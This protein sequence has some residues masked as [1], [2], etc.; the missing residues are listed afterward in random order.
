[1]IFKLDEQVKRFEMVKRGVRGLLCGGCVVGVMV[2]GGCG[3]EQHGDVAVSELGVKTFNTWVVPADDGIVPAPRSITIG[4]DDRV[5]V[6]DNGGR[7][8]IYSKDGELE[9]QFDM[10]TNEAGNPEGACWLRDGRIVVADTHYFRLVFFNEDGE[11]VETRGSKSEK[12]EKGKYIYPVDVVQDE[13]GFIYVAE[14]GGNDRVQKFTEDGEFVFDF[15]KFG[16][17]P[18]EFQ[19]CAGMF[20]RGEEIWVADATNGR[21]QVFNK[22][23]GDYL[24]MLGQERELDEVESDGEIAVV[25]GSEDG[26]RRGPWGE[27]VFNY[28]YDLAEGEDGVYVLEW[29][30]GRFVKIGFDGEVKGFYGK[31]GMRE[32]EFRTPWGIGVDSRGHVR[33]ADTKNRRVVEVVFE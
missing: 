31:P 14:Y 1:M 25:A 30:G 8:L 9:K 6:L 12:G 3:G 11:V 24:R 7:V 21:V 26:L 28:P 4:E 20:I 29:G 17:G 27:Y 16:T 18:G 33:V 23:T 15:G 10:P 22:D 32:G 13:D 5:L 2:I 19:R